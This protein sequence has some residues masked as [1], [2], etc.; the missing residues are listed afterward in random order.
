MQRC[1]RLQST[2]LGL[3]FIALSA[4]AQT[5]RQSAEAPSPLFGGMDPSLAPGVDFFGYA[6]GGWLKT[7]EIPADLPS[8]GPFDQLV[9]L[10]EKRLSDL[11]RDVARSNPPAAS[12]ERKVA[13]F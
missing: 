8:Y 10:N 13:E 9:E 6:N 2:A 11:I 4:S 3:V 1:P 12:D 7:T 5:P